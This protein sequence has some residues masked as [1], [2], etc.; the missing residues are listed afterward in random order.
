MQQRYD[1]LLEAPRPAPPLPAPRAPSAVEAP[2]G[3]RLQ[4]HPEGLTPTEI[5]TRLH[6]D[7]RLRNT[8]LAML[9]DGLRWRVEPGR[10]RAAEP[11]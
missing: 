10:Y 8:C 6:A 5:R 4:A 7:K 3:I 11:S 9:R 1:R 2:R